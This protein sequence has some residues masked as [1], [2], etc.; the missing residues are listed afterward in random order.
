MKMKKLIVFIALVL[1][2]TTVLFAEKT[3]T[4]QVSLKTDKPTVV[5]FTDGEYVT[6][7][8]DPQRVG[9]KT[10]QGNE[11]S[12]RTTTVWASVRSFDDTSCSMKLTWGPL[13]NGEGGTEIPLYVKVNS[14]KA[15]PINGST[16]TGSDLPSETADG[17]TGII[18]ADPTTGSFNT[19][20]ITHEL[21]ITAKNDDIKNVVNDTYE[22]T[23]TLTTD[24]I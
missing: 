11:G 3:D 18:L 22:A 21:V 5:A 17:T 20:A 2:S 19:R 24:Y 13:N 1:V 23:L 9:G 10:L 4:L 12:D 7:G 14:S 16:V 8:S 6:P 15:T